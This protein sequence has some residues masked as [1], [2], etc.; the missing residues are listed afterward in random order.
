MAAEGGENG[1]VGINP[2]CV[3]APMPGGD[4]ASVEVEDARKFRAVEA[5]NRAPVPGWRERRDDAQALFT[6]DWGWRAAF[7]A[8]TSLRSC[9]ISS[10][11]SA[12]LTRAGSTSSP[13]GVP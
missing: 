11:S 6:F 2:E 8:A 12:S 10:S 7:S 1:D 4:H 5:G 3:I 9:A 13:H